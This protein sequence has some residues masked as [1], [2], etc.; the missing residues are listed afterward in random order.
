MAATYNHLHPLYLNIH[1]NALS[2]LYSLKTL[3][4]DANIM[5]FGHVRFEILNI[6]LQLAAIFKND[7]NVIYVQNLLRKH[8]HKYFL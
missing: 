5:A 7:R 1:L 2:E 8:S 3:Y 4:M 6:A